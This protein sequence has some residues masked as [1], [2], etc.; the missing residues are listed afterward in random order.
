MVVEHTQNVGYVQCAHTLTKQAAV[1]DSIYIQILQH[2]QQQ[3]AL[4]K[5]IHRKENILGDFRSIETILLHRYTSQ[6]LG[7]LL[8]STI[9]DYKDST[10]PDTDT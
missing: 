7:A 2:Q 10:A 1:R 4:A 9:S 8:A 5:S 6:G 3:Q